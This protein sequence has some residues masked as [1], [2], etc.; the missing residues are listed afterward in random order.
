[1]MG[2]ETQ[3]NNALLAHRIL[4]IFSNTGAKA[5]LALF[6]RRLFDNSARFNTLLCNGLIGSVLFWGISSLIVLSASCPFTVFTTTTAQCT[7][8]VSQARPDI[9]N[10][11]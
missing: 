3:V 11:H 10:I 1:M 9:C 5:S 7:S 8:E 4:Y 2:R 6:V